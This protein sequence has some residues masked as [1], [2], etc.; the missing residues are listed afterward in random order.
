MAALVLASILDKPTAK[1]K[2][3]T[4]SIR[5]LSMA[6]AS[7]RVSIFST[8]GLVLFPLTVILVPLPI[9]TTDSKGLLD[10]PMS[11]SLFK[12]ATLAPLKEAAIR[13]GLP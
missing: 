11:V 8:P 10:V 3:S 2:P 13:F 12:T 1:A 4:V 9:L 5:T 7:L 6:V